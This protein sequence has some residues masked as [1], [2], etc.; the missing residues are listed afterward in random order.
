MVARCWNM[1]HWG[2][3]KQ[4]NIGWGPTST[5]DNGVHKIW[6]WPCIVYAINDSDCCLGYV[7]KSKQNFNAVPEW[8]WATVVMKN[9]GKL[10]C[11]FFNPFRPNYGPNG[12]VPQLILRCTIEKLSWLSRLPEMLVKKT[13]SKTTNK[14]KGGKK[15]KSQ[16]N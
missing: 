14:S 7:G 13:A 4:I 3:V 9:G 11:F 5:S 10:I 1:L 2:F 8:F 15:R 12:F 16:T 6:V